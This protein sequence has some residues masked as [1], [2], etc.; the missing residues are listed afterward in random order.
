[1]LSSSLG[2]FGNVSIWLTPVWLLASGVTLGLIV[3]GVLFGIVWL[4][5]RNT[6]STIRAAVHE[7]FLFPVLALGAAL[8][9]FTVAGVA[10]V[11]FKPLMNSITRLASSTEI[12]ET[13]AVAA[14]AD[15]LE[16]DLGLVPAEVRLLR[17]ESDRNMYISVE[18]PGFGSNR[19]TSVA[20]E[21]IEQGVPFV[22]DRGS[23]AQYLFSGDTTRIFLTNNSGLPGTV[24]VLA[25][26]QPEYPEAIAI[27]VTAASYVGLVLAFIAMRLLF[28][29]VTAVATT[30]AKEALA[31]PIFQIVLAIG[32]VLLIVTVF[33]PYNT[34]GEDVKVLK[35]FNLAF[36]MLLSIFI[37]LWTASVGISEEIEGRTALT[38]LSKPISRAQFLLGKFVGVLL[39]VILMFLFLGTVFLISVSFKLTYDARE[40]ALKNPTWQNCY[41]EMI[42]IVPGLLLAFMEAVVMGSI[43]VAIATRLP[44]LANLVICFSIYV[45][46]HLLPLLVL[47]K[48]MSDPFGI[49][50]FAGQFFATVLPV[51]EHFNIN[52]AIAG[53]AIVPWS[54]LGWALAY[55]V[56]YS[57]VAMLFALVLFEDRD[58][59]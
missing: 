34:F 54:Y 8:T 37:A 28:P 44:M 40:S 27:P 17:L 3:L 11:P 14:D 15:N 41:A 53:G 35:D 21:S 33:I 9:V 29:R 48:R 20:R 57:T 49:V 46:G 13:V 58:L 31:Q 23:N 7:G 47:S 36:V 39:P 45:I 18:L 32:I 59:A 26:T 1:M 12:T 24:K 55:C 22:W 4:V 42:G 19:P 6:A 43:S 52:A 30:T 2:L 25:Q 16:V 38:V 50:H 5:S 56:L 51:L 10:L